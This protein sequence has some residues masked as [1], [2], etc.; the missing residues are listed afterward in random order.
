V[1]GPTKTLTFSQIYNFFK[2]NDNFFYLLLKEKVADQ[3]WKG[4]NPIRHPTCTLLSIPQ[5]LLPLPQP[6]SSSSH[7]Y[8][9]APSS[10][11]H[12]PLFYSF[13]SSTKLT[14]N[15]HCGNSKHILPLMAQPR[16]TAVPKT[17]PCAFMWR[18]NAAAV[19]LMQWI[20]ERAKALR[21]Y[22]GESWCRLS[23]LETLFASVIDF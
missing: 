4:H 18:V 22:G 11:S 1:R 9:H 13:A 5:L 7:F 19:G 6:E 3:D 12:S 14:S 21:D 8:S 15:P 23:L 16:A 20:L 2:Y 17:L 10:L